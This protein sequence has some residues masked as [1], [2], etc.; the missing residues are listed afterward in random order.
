MLAFVAVL[1]PVLSNME[2]DFAKLHF[3][4]SLGSDKCTGSTLP[5]AASCSVQ[6]KS[7]YVSNGGDPYFGCFQTLSHAP[8][9]CTLPL[10]VP[11]ANALTSTANQIVWCKAGGAHSLA[12]LYLL[13][14]CLFEEAC[15]CRKGLPVLRWSVEASY[16][17]YSVEILDSARQHL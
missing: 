2:P 9:E 13:A 5:F 12:S 14:T 8:L 16:F 4:N 1:M 10:A 3:E 11:G 6:C 15:S 7:G 17:L